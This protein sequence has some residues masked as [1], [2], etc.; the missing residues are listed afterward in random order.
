MSMKW[1]IR[2][3][4]PSL[5]WG[6][7]FSSLL[8]YAC[9]VWISTPAILAAVST[10]WQMRAGPGLYSSMRLTLVISAIPFCRP[11]LSCSFHSQSLPRERYRNEF[12]NILRNQTCGLDVT[13]GEGWAVA[14]EHN[15]ARRKGYLPR[16]LRHAKCL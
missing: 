9:I 2:N 10:L 3:L 14:A 11:W 13:G 4:L 5:T 16:W 6:T 12:G 15:I 7:P 8:I 1:G